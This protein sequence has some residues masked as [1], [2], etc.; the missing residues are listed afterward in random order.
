MESNTQSATTEQEPHPSR[1]LDPV[2]RTDTIRR[3]TGYDPKTGAAIYEGDNPP[4]V[5]DRNAREPVAPLYTDDM[6]RRETPTAA[7]R[8]EQRN[9]KIADFREQAIANVMEKYYAQEIN[10]EAARLADEENERRKI[11]GASHY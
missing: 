4:N 3:V 11:N 8:I 9:R 1:V 6:A 10:G 7:T 5:V 2:Q